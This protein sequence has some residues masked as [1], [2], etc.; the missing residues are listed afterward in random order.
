MGLFDWLFGGG[1]TRQ[2]VRTCTWCGNT[3]VAG[4]Y[5][6]HIRTR[7]HKAH[8]V[9]HQERSSRRAVV[10]RPPAPV[11]KPRPVEPAPVVDRRPPIV[12]RVER[13]KALAARGAARTEAED[14]E[15]SHLLARRNP[16]QLGARTLA[17]HRGHAA[18]TNPGC[19]GIE[20]ARD[21]AEAFHGPRG[22]GAVVC[23]HGRAHPVVGRLQA[24]E[25]SAPRGSE[26]A[27][28]VW[29]HEAGDAGD[30][31]P[32]LKGRALV[33]ADAETGRV[34]LA[35][36]PARFDEHRGLVG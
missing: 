29:R 10:Q 13:I 1:R 35:G 5:R 19:P 25:Y 17:H 16:L 36:G 15:L 30:F 7:A 14:Q 31:A 20:E 12:V 8:L 6:G 33:V 4:R 3:Y 32:R 34:E 26:R 2:D 23:L 24:I 21:Q 9:S 27:G 22:R 18:R 11:R 28:D